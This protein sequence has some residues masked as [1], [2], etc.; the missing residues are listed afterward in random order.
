MKNSCYPLQ[1]AR[2]GFQ[3]FVAF[4]LLCALISTSAFQ[5]A[6]FA[7]QA[8]TANEGGNQTV[9]QTQE[10]TGVGTGQTASV[11]IIQDKSTVVLMESSTKTVLF[12]KEADKRIYPASM[13]K[14]LTALV[15][16]DYFQPSDVITVGTEINEVPYDSSK[17]GHRVG[18]I[19]SMEN[20]IRGLII[21]SGNDTANVLAAA[22]AKKAQNNDALT[23]AEC[24]EFFSGLMNEKA[25]QIGA[26]NSHFT[27][28]HGYH[29][30]NHYST[31]YDIALI[32]IEA[33]KNDTIRNIAQETGFTG[34]GAGSTLENANNVI[35]T[36]YNW[37]SHNLLITDGAYHYEY[38]TGLKTGFT[39]EAGNCIAATATKDDMELIAIVCNS[40]DPNR[41]TE[42]K[43][44]FEYGFQ[45]FHFET[46]QKSGTVVDTANLSNHNRLNGDTLDVVVKDDI[47]KLLSKEQLERVETSIIYTKVADKETNNDKNSETGNTSEENTGQP[48]EEASNNPVE[49]TGPLLLAPIEKD[50]LIGTI[51]Y[52]LDGTVIATSNVYA[53]D[54]VEKSTILNSIQFFFKDLIKNIATP[55][56]IMKIAAGII[57]IA[58]IIF[59]ITIIHRRRS[60]NRSR[61]KYRYSSNLK[62]RRRK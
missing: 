38:A 26:V 33:M 35:T 19:L 45:T 46:L 6:I 13:T 25:K 47:T 17:A 21:P 22:V 12:Q 11:P 28:P 4:T 15:V 42:A 61:S 10:E 8:P 2:K 49:P 14:I 37:T 62:R 7:E 43:D 18:E 27:N 31:A 53:S 39:D 36:N 55:G 51:N 58:V 30:E 41:W 32:S 16:L 54:V 3:K 60:Y 34:N 20:L 48:S 40:D 56:G 5:P 29:D 59:I 50:E 9:G 44:M 24:E 23:Y 52:E 1:K 57:V